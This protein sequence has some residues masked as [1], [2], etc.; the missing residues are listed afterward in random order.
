VKIDTDLVNQNYKMWSLRDDRFLVAFDKSI[1][2]IMNSIDHTALFKD[3]LF[4]DDTYIDPDYIKQSYPFE[5]AVLNNFWTYVLDK[6]ISPA[7]PNKKVS[8]AEI[9]LAEGLSDGNYNWHT[10][11]DGEYNNDKDTP[12]CYQDIIC[13]YYFNDT[14]YGPLCLKYSDRKGLY[15]VY[16][17][18]GMLAILN[19]YDDGLIHKIEYYE[20][21]Q[22]KRYTARISFKVE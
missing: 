21:E 8:L 22:G 3:P 12:L 11:K 19:E 5:W 20:K 14:D 18:K 15:K 10:D 9:K 4:N 2:S 1:E 6:Y 7:F 16:P 17:Q 13:L